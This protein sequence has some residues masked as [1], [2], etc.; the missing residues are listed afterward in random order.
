MRTKIYRIGG[1][2]IFIEF[3][4][5]I[6][7][8]TSILPIVIARSVVIPGI[9]PDFVKIDFQN[10]RLFADSKFTQNASKIRSKKILIKE[11]ITVPFLKNRN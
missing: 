1:L 4:I 7:D 2:S 5:K 3:T 11:A 8:I 10:C 6:I 9:F